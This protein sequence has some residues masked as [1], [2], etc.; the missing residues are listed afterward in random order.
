MIG[1]KKF[2]TLSEAKHY[3]KDRKEYYSPN[4]YKIN[5]KTYKYFVGTYLEWINF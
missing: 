3:L 4:I 1:G 5:G 2:K